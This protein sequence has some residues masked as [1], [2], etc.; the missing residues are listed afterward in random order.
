M[1]EKEPEKW[2]KIEIS[3]PV[4]AHGRAW[5]IFSPKQA[6]RAYFRNH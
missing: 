1:T 3:A 4:R 5:E 2:L 6:L